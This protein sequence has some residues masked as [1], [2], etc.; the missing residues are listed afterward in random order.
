[1]V[2]TQVHFNHSL[3]AIFGDIFYSTLDTRQLNPSNT[4][5]EKLTRELESDKWYSPVP[6]KVENGLARPPFLSENPSDLIQFLSALEETGYKIA[7]LLLQRVQPVIQL[8]EHC[9]IRY[10][11]PVLSPDEH[12][13][14]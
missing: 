11:T 2:V 12:K 5:Y 9:F 8:L 4:G 7:H 14:T 13:L 1:M 10:I 3:R 6:Q